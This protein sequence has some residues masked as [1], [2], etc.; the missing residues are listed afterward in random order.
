MII[1]KNRFSTINYLKTKDIAHLTRK[2]RRACSTEYEKVGMESKFST[3]RDFDKNK[4]TI[5]VSSQI[6]PLT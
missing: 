4:M 3:H 1:S 6:K 2:E 5:F